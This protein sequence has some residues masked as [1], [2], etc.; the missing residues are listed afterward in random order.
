M[1]QTNQWGRGA[2]ASALSPIVVLVPQVAGLTGR[3]PSSDRN[4][5]SLL[6]LWNHSSIPVALHMGA[7]EVDPQLAHWEPTLP[8]SHFV[9][10]P[11]LVVQ[12]QLC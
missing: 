7:S 9:S 8:V 3:V 11:K 5:D 12:A 10:T 4:A 6:V 2:V 1:R